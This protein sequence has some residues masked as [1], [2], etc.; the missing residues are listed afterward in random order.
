MASGEGSRPQPKLSVTIPRMEPIVRLAMAGTVSLEDAVPVP[1]QNQL[2]KMV[3][4]RDGP[5]S[6]SG[7][8]LVQLSCEALT[9]SRTVAIFPSRVRARYGFCKN[10]RRCCTARSKSLTSL[11]RS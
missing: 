8:G 3:G 2:T 4:P 10:A 6:G 11:C 9:P 7:T 5:G 1:D